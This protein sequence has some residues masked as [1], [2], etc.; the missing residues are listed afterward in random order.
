MACSATTFTDCGPSRT[1]ICCLGSSFYLLLRTPRFHD[2][3]AG[4]SNGTTVNMLPADGLQKPGFVLPPKPLVDQFG[5][6]FNPL[7]RRLD[8]LYDENNT[9]AALRDALLPKLIS[10]EL[11]VPDAERI[12]GR[13][14]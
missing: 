10:G 8:G 9:L 2:L 3:V 5:S 11:R 1:A 4:H 14:I 6:L 13:C 12:V 7:Q